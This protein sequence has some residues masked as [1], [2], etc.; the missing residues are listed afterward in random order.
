MGFSKLNVL[1]HD[2][3]A[4]YFKKFLV[5]GK[6]PETRAAPRQQNRVFNFNFYILKSFNMLV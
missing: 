2:N 3:F 1:K 6:V 5:D 4:A